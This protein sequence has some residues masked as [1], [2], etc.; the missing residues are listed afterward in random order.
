[1]NLRQT[2]PY[3]HRSSVVYDPTTKTWI[4]VTHMPEGSAVSLHS[5]IDL[6]IP[7]HCG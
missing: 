7:L 5:H 2:P 3:G 1:M 4:T 6:I